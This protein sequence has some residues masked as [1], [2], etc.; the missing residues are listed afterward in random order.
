MAYGLEDAL[1]LGTIVHER[2]RI[3]AIVGRGGV[4]TVYQ[5]HDV[6][7]GK[8]NAYALKELADP[9]DGAR[10]QF[11]N[12]AQWLQALDHNNIPKV[13]E[14]FLWENRMY[15]V[16]DFVDGENLEQRLMREGGR[17]LPE[18]QVLNWI[19]PIC[20]ALTY[21]HTRVPPILHR[22]IKPANIIVT[23][24]GH[25][26]LVDLGIAKQHLPGAGLTATFVRK[27]GTE[28]YAPPEQY[29]TAGRTGPWSDVYGLGATLYELLTGQVPPTAVERVALDASTVRPRAVN[30]AVSAIVDDAIMRA[31]AVRPIDRFQTIAEFVAAVQGLPPPPPQPRT[32]DPAFRSFPSRGS[33]FPMGSGSTNSGGLG[34]GIGSGP[35]VRSGPNPPV[36]SNPFINSGPTYSPPQPRPAAG[37]AVSDL[38]SLGGPMGPSVRQSVAP[39]IIPMPAHAPGS[40]PPLNPSFSNGAAS[41][42]VG[43]AP[44]K[45]SW[46]R[47]RPLVGDVADL[48]AR[49]PSTGAGNRSRIR[50]SL[51]IGLVVALAVLV[52]AVLFGQPLLNGA[53]GSF[54]PPDRSTAENTVNGYFDALTTSN[55]DRAWQYLADSRN[56]PQNK[57]A[58]ISRLSDDER[59]LGRVTS[60]AVKQ[61]AQDT[62]GRV[63]IT[64]SVTR[65]RAPNL[66]LTV[67]V[68]LSQYNGTDWLIE[69]LTTV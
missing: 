10:K 17:G 25:P 8:N 9:S 46:I 53:L 55:Y 36:Q 30:S 31:L 51:V 7:F 21:L 60:V 34:L 2:Y 29:T 48:G 14:F 56:S 61:R 19:M 42:P 1:P 69:S 28:G 54:F 39:S 50:L 68:S 43:R 41:V 4:G 64:L 66:P 38:P 47:S 12:E 20:D 65:A 40:L 3:D 59:N 11:E 37:D 22:D 24:A 33:D 15:L 23:P 35:F 58:V 52:G 18:A 27:A 26:V 62:S 49:A 32:A 44:V 67:V 13:R 57:T 16:M 45:S 6:L 63:N 5:V